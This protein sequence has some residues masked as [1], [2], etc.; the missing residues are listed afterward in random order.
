MAVFSNNANYAMI[1]FQKFN[2][3][4]IE[5]YW[6]PKWKTIANVYKTPMVFVLLCLFLNIISIRL[7]TLLESANK[8]FFKVKF[9]NFLLFYIWVYLCFKVGDNGSNVQCNG[10]TPFRVQIPVQIKSI[11]CEINTG[12]PLSNSCCVFRPAFGCT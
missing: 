6:T 12:S 8:H 5:C 10:L 9:Q 1:N 7:A 11:L 3:A 4:G 2:H